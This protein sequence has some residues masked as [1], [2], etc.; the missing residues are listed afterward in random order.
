MSQMSQIA[1]PAFAFIDQLR[2]TFHADLRPMQL[3]NYVSGQWIAGSDKQAER[4][5][6]GAGE[7]V[8]TTRIR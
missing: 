8:A 7:L 5:D 1:H 3:Q 2:M 6:T 4:V